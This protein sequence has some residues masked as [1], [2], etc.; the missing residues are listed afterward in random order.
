MMDLA[1]LESLYDV[2]QG[3]DLP[4]PPELAML[5]GRLSFPAHADRLHVVSTAAQIC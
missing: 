1:P 2:E 5:Y 3:S 4:L